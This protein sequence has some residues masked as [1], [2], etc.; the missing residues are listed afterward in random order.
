MDTHVKRGEVYL[1]HQ[2]H[3]EKWRRMW[4]VLY[5]SS[6]RG[7]ARLEMSDADSGG[8]KLLVV[9]RSRHPERRVVRLADCVSVVQLPPHAEACPG[10]N[11]A[12]FCVETLERR[13]VFAT[14]RDSCADWVERM[15]Q[16]AFPMDTG[17]GDVQKQKLQMEEN[18]IY[19]SRNEIPEFRVNVQ[20]TEA[21]AR[22]GLKG[23]YWLQ[24]GAEC[25]LLKDLESHRTV[26]EWPYNLL[27]RYGRDKLVFLIE[28]GRRCESGPGAFTFETQQGDDIFSRIETAVQEQ[29]SSALAGV[30]RRP[31]SP[32]PSIP[33]SAALA[34]M[35][36][37]SSSRVVSDSIN[38]VGAGKP[39][40]TDPASVISF[41][42]PML[43]N[44]LDP[45]DSPEIVYAD[46]MDAI[47]TPYPMRADQ[48]SAPPPTIGLSESSE[49][50]YSSPVN[51]VCPRLDPDRCDDAEPVYSEVY[52]EMPDIA[53]PLHSQQ[54]AVYSEPHRAA[55]PETDLSQSDVRGG[56]TEDKP[57][58][59]PSALYSK[60]NKPPKLPK[61]LST[62]INKPPKLSQTRHRLPHH[63]QSTPD[64]VC[65][66]LGVI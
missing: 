56:V 41:S 11:M 33:N 19:V 43:S 6:R 57:M 55:N 15:C 64:V 63:G 49:P 36:S 1:Q 46:P 3:D 16:I 51:C 48:P 13:L 40:Y 60:V 32:L 17:N 2:K 45:P 12:A 20:T 9:V 7:V 10:D 61:N 58:D 25:L 53:L 66:D 34:G 30:K 54:E 31:N 35:S 59:D 18:Q 27:R 52:N 8:D 22:C 62:Q 24:A 44:V 38:I 5:A 65:E 50:V 42:K 39:I 23:A 47:R 37:D 28:A 14:E 29:S 26:L 21:S 4:L